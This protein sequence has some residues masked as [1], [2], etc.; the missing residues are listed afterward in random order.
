MIIFVKTVR[1]QYSKNKEIEHY[2]SFNTYSILTIALFSF[3][4]LL[5]LF[6]NAIIKTLILKKN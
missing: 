5:E 1:T 4:V 6:V 2:G 3:L